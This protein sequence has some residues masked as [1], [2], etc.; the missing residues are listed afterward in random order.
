MVRGTV[1]PQGE[2]RHHDH[3][4]GRQS[5]PEISGDLAAHPRSSAGA[6]DR[7]VREGR[8]GPIAE[9]ERNRG[10][11]DVSGELGRMIDVVPA[12]RGD[13]GLAQ[14]RGEIVQA[15]G[16]S[17][18]APRPSG[19]GRGD[20]D[21]DSAITDPC[22]GGDGVV[23]GKQPGQSSCT[24]SGECGQ[25]SDALSGGGHRRLH[26]RPSAHADCAGQVARPDLAF[27]AVEVGDRASHGA[28]P[29]RASRAQRAPGHG[30][31]KQLGRV[32][33]QRGVT[34]ELLTVHRSVAPDAALDRALTDCG[35]SGRN[36]GRAF[37]GLGIEERQR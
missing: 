17:R 11:I 16:R 5:G 34:V 6:D 3:P 18:I 15:R 21:V 32:V 37:P 24:G 7:D 25:R 12:R 36:G 27:V 28:R 1:D 4:R 33:R 8:V 20:V 31:P 10:R 19:L 30:R 35:D 22:P 29:H 26:R 9:P 23:G 2:P 14:R 13:T